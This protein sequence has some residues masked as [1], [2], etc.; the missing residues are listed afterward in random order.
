MAV[1]LRD[2]ETECAKLVAYVI[3]SGESVPS[4]KEV[5]AFLA[6]SVPGYMFRTW[7]CR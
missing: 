2:E 3:P 6:R 1:A 5:R 4:I 7:S